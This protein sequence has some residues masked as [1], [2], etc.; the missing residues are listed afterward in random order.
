MKEIAMESNVLLFGWDR[1]VPGR[2]SLSAQHFQEFVEYLTEQQRK[3]QVESFEPVFLDSHGGTFNGFVLI[4]GE[5]GKLDDLVRSR[6]WVQHITRAMLHLQGAGAVR[7]V[8]GQSLM[9]RME[10]WTKLIPGQA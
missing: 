7:G 4:R 6:E 1:S 10:M 8:T 2:E 5:P 9:A 3:G